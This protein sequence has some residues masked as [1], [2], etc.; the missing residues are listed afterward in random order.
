MQCIGLS[1][2]VI[3]SST[4]ILQCVRLAHMYRPRGLTAT[5][6]SL[7]RGNPLCRSA[8]AALTT[9][10]SSESMSFVA[11]PGWHLWSKCC[12]AAVV[13]ARTCMHTWLPFIWWRFEISILIFCFVKLFGA[14]TDNHRY[15]H[16]K[17]HADFVNTT[18]L[19]SAAAA[20]P[21]CVPG[22]SSNSSSHCIDDVSNLK[23]SKIFLTRG[24]CRTYT[25]NAVLNSVNVYKELGSSGIL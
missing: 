2:S 6:Y 17:S 8:S 15:D 3:P 18:L 19:S 7:K 22:G 4:W 24:E 13:V 21:A 9:A 20:V 14:W 10:P 11:L 16:C 25:G 5:L 12:G 1:P 23:Q